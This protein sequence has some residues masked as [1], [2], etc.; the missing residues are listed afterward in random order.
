MAFSKTQLTDIYH[1][2]AAHYDITA[3]LYYLL[4]FREY[5]YRKQAVVALDLKPGDTVVEL[6]CGTGLNFSLLQQAV[7]PGGKII[8]IDLTSKMLSQAKARIAKH[9]WNNVELIQTDAATF[10][11]PENVGGVLST[12]ALTL[13]PEYDKVIERASSALSSGKRFVI[14]DIKLPERMPMWLVHFGMLIMRP[15]GVS[16][17]LAVRHPWESIEQHLNKLRFEEL[18]LG[19]AYISVGERDESLIDK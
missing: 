7:G 4:G 5:A 11:F 14:L 6:G 15:F 8:G 16:L 18:Y 1:R 2:R 17:D 19:F 13:V 12:F 10:E 3:N 9:N